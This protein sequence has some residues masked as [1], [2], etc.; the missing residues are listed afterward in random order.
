MA[1]TRKYTWYDKFLFVNNIIYIF[2]IGP[3]AHD[4]TKFSAVKPNKPSFKITS[5][6]FVDPNFTAGPY[7]VI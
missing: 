7:A 6:F 1:E 3:G 2:F 5:T 4:H